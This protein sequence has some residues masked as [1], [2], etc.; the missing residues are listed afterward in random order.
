MYSLFNIQMLIEVTSHT[1]PFLS[2]RCLVI[3]DIGLDMA[4]GSLAREHGKCELISSQVLM[5]ILG[6]S[7]KV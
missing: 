1:P 6:I 2:L 7:D 5:Y 4:G 3:Q